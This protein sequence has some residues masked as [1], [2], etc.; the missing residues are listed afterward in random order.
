MTYIYVLVGAYLI[1]LTICAV[2]AKASDPR[3]GVV[4]ANTI[5]ATWNCQDKIPTERTAARSPW[6][7]HTQ[8]Y[9]ARE[10][11]LW[12][13]RLNNIMG[14]V[15]TSRIPRPRQPSNTMAAIRCGPTNLRTL[16]TVRM[17]MP[18]CL[19]EALEAKLESFAMK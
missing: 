10:L 4:I 7:H 8:A 2:T 9:W 17:G 11:N 19:N 15:Q 13:L 14:R 3:H 18:Q 6:K 16:R 1:L 12:T 5:V